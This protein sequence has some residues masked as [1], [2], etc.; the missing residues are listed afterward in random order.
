MLRYVPAN[1]KPRAADPRLHA[2][3]QVTPNHPAPAAG[4][5]AAVV[6]LGVMAFGTAVGLL[7]YSN[8]KSGL[9]IVAIG[10]GSSIAGAGLILLVLDV[11]GFKPI[12]F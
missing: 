2:L 5:P 11:L 7:G 1:L 4:L 10:A 3:S 6:N 8:R 9:G 12:Q